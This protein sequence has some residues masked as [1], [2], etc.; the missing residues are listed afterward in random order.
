MNL[1]EKKS[2]GITGSTFKMIACLIMFV[3]HIGAV[4]IEKYL[5]TLSGDEFYRIYD[6]DLII[7]YIGR[8]AFPMFCFLLVEGFL[9]T[10][11]R[12]RYA[13][14]LLVFG[15]LSEIPFNLAISGGLWDNTHQNV[16]FTLLIGLGVMIFCEKLREKWQKP[17]LQ[18]IGMAVIVPTGAILA[19]YLRTDYGKIGVITIFVMYLLRNNKMRE[20]LAGSIVL[21]ADN[22]MEWTALF[23][24]IPV[25][26][27][28]GKKGKLP[29]LFFYLFYPVHLLALCGIRTW[30]GY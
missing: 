13:V 28:N 22:A 19:E 11:S 7:R 10:K 21:M 20:M 2:F 5:R 23:A 30:L 8:L 12:A 16:F 26:L 17:W 3:D 1:Q 9:Y 14:R 15:I 25:A 4:I 18:F 24:L 6:F 27:Y 29:K